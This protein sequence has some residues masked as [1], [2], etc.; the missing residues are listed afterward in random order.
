MM[1]LKPFFALGLTVGFVVG[2]A[3]L[4]QAPLPR[5]QPTS[6]K[7]YRPWRA[8]LMLS[9]EHRTVWSLAYRPDGK[10]LAGGTGENNQD[11]ITY[12]WDASTGERLL[13]LCHVQGGRITSVA[14]SPDGSVIATV[15]TEVRFWDARTGQQRGSLEGKF[16]S[17]AFSR[18]GKHL[19][20]AN[21]G[22]GMKLW[23]VSTGKAVRTFEGSAWDVG[24]VSPDGNLVA[25]YGP[26]EKMPVKVWEVS[27]G[28]L[29]RTLGEDQSVLAFSPDNKRLAAL[30]F[31]GRMWVR[32]VADD[33]EVFTVEQAHYRAARSRIA[34]T[35]DGTRLV[36]T[37]ERKYS[38][39]IPEPWHPE[40]DVEVKV[41][42]ASTGK[43]LL[44]FSPSRGALWCADV[45]PNG[46]RIAVSTSNY[47]GVAIWKFV[48]DE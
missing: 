14:F 10:Q 21:A 1:P 19:L 26:G 3:A 27:S 25:G 36:S 24:A 22:D 13:R 37:A 2:G 42:D 11:G 32:D 47:N 45:A 16:G 39:F 5:A 9:S 40:T 7:L 28:R 41:F 43:E 31:Y 17:V 8:S 29:L 4:A 23:D 48:A 15:G 38:A 18:D 12:V 33:K 20:A 35:A 46:R 6:P 44:A 30:A 34:F